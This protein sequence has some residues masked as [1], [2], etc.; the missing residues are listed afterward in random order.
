LQGDQPHPTFQWGRAAALPDFVGTSLRP[1]PFDVP[2]LNADP[3]NPCPE[4]KFKWVNHPT[5]SNVFCYDCKS[6]PNFGQFWH[7]P[8]V[9]HWMLNMCV[10]TIHFTWRMYT[11]RYLVMLRERKLWQNIV[12]SC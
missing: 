5:N 3:Y 8:S 1:A 10:Q 11:L 12:V 7:I 9:Q 2:Y 6:L 4:A